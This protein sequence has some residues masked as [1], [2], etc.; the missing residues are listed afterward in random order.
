MINLKFQHA[1]FVFTITV[2]DPTF[3]W[4]CFFFIMDKDQKI[5]FPRFY[6][7]GIVWNITSNLVI[8][9]VGTFSK[10]VMTVLNKTTVINK[11]RLVKLLERTDGR[12]LITFSNH[13]SCFDEPGLWGVLPFR[14][15]WS[16]KVMRWSTA[17]HDVCFTT[18]LHTYFFS[19]G[20]CLPIIRGGGVYQEGIDYSIDR[21]NEGD[22]VHIFPEG[23]VNGDKKHIRL[24]WGVGRMIMECKE[25][26][27][28]LPLFHT[29]MEEV[30]PNQ[31][32]YRLKFGSF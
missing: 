30:L 5:Y 22:W 8:G 11:D 32:P 27:L 24:K 6:G 3:I 1:P 7:K 15:L 4:N 9:A 16:R 14:H 12:P 26:P 19:L 18:P 17:A 31:A 2:I 23:K 10:V 25:E 21:L 29:D 28:V 20:K 13:D